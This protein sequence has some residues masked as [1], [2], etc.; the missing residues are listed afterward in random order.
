MHVVRQ[1]HNKD[2]FGGAKEHAVVKRSGFGCS[3]EANGATFVF[4]PNVSFFA[5]VLIE[6]QDSA[7][8][9]TEAPQA[10]KSQALETCSQ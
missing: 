10:W 1:P 3:M 4:R 6:V 9:R 8:N 2:G 5:D 7:P